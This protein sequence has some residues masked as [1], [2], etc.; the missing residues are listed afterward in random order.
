VAIRTVL[1]HLDDV[2]LLFTPHNIGQGSAH[3]GPCPN[4]LVVSL[5]ISHHHHFVSHNDDGTESDMQGT[6]AE[7]EALSVHHSSILHENRN[8]YQQISTGSHPI[9][10]PRTSFFSNRFFRQPIRTGAT[11]SRRVLSSH[12]QT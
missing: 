8:V 4:S 9:F 5:P 11:W 1:F 3:F 6:T 2:S 7:T 12:S 10:A